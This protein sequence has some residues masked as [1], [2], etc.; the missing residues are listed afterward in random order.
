E[1]QPGSDHGTP[2]AAGATHDRHEQVFDTVI[3]AEGAGTDR[4]LHVGV[5]PAGQAGQQGGVDE[6]DDLVPGRVDP[7]GFGHALPAF[8]RADG[9]ARAGIKQIPG[10]PQAEQYA[11]PDQIVDTA[12]FGKREP[13]DIQRLNACNAVVLAQKSHIPEKVVQR[14]TPR[15]GPERE[16][17]AGEPKCQRAQYVGG[18]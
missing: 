8:Q 13:E 10:A 18:G 7:E 1:N 5:D 4:P 6:D 14:Q 3:Q 9:A 11:D 12:A 2:D 15:D 16:I 17:V